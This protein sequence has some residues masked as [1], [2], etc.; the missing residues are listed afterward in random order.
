MIKEDCDAL[1][2]KI[3]ECIAAILREFVTTEGLHASVVIQLFEVKKTQLNKNFSSFS[4]TSKYNNH[5]STQN[6]VDDYCER[7]CNAAMTAM[8]N[9]PFTPDEKDN[10]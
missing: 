9:E 4:C 1:Q 2:N 10:V 6:L 8:D 3:A 7:A 5:K